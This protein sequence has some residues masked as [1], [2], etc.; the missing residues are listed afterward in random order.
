M[1]ASDITAI[2]QLLVAFGSVL[3][4]IIAW[5]LAFLIICILFR[6]P[7]SSA[8]VILAR[9]I[10]KAGP[11]EFAGEIQTPDKNTIK[12]KKALEDVIGEQSTKNINTSLNDD[13]EKNPLIKTYITFLKPQLEESYNHYP[14]TD[15]TEFL[16]AKI[17][18]IY[19]AW[20]FEKIYSRIFESQIQTLKFLCINGYNSEKSEI[21]KFYNIAKEHFPELYTN[22]SF[23]NWLDFM[24]NQSVISIDG[25]NINLTSEGQGFINYI[26]H[27]KLARKSY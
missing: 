9:R 4:S 25:D 2:S 19:L 6:A 1:T 12:N 7:L 5:P 24:K 14:G 21:L 10:T 27:H 13:L 20:S 3:T 23:E 11:A 8:I 18:E 26:A 15:K 16:Y 17:S 22:Y